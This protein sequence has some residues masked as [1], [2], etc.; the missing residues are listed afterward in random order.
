[1]GTTKRCSEAIWIESKQYWQVKVQRDGVRKGFTS[2]I[3]G[4]R[5]KHEAEAKA[6][7]WLELGLDEIRLGAAWDAL[8]EYQKNGRAGR[9]IPKPNRMADYTCSR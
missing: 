9:T 1:M 2:S 6:D 3:P 7:E 5:G 8:Y 4:R